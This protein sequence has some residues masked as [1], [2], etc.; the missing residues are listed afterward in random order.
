MD[1]QNYGKSQRQRK[2]Q[3]AK[4]R[5][6]A[7]EETKKNKLSRRKKA[8]AK[9]TLRKAFY[10]VINEIDNDPFLRNYLFLAK[11]AKNK[12]VVGGYIIVKTDD[13]YFNIYKKTMDSLIYENVFIF[14]AALAIVEALN[15]G[16]E[17]RVKTILEAEK[18]YANNYMEMLFFKQAYK[19]AVETDLG[20][21]H[22]FEDRYIVV[23]NRA[24]RALKEIHKFRIAKK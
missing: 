10:S 3:P 6:M 14:D 17:K 19:N 16:Y 22:V 15:T 9:T 4:K 7:S 18:I 11:P 8:K 1:K 13:S 20:N 24:K 2:G 5:V 21:A 12:L 23:K